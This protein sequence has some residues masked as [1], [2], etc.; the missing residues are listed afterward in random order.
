MLLCHG[1]ATKCPVFLD[2]SQISKIKETQSLS[3]F[4]EE[5]LDFVDDLEKNLRNLF[6]Y[7]RGFYFLR[8]LR[9]KTMEEFST[10]NIFFRNYGDFC[11]KISKDDEWKKIAETLSKDVENDL[12]HYMDTALKN[13]IIHH[14][15]NPEKLKQFFECYEGI[16]DLLASDFVITSCIPT[17]IKHILDK[18]ILHGETNDEDVFINQCI[19]FANR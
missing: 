11:S 13:F 14:E 5:F 15:N 18:N 17:M 10:K 19:E 1:F 9:M 4:D 8:I 12:Y 16:G 7:Q 2:D 3:E 6:D